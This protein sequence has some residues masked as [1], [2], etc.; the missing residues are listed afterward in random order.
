MNSFTKRSFEWVFY[1]TAALLFIGVLIRSVLIFSGSAYLPQ[2]L[3]L[4]SAWLVLAASETIISKRV[5]YYF[6]LYLVC[7]TTLVFVLINTPDF[8][9]FFAALLIIISMQV[10][11]RLNPK[12]GFAWMGLCALIMV[13]VMFRT[14]QSQAVALAL[15]YTGANIL[16]GSY[17][18]AARRSQEARLQN[19]SLAKQL[20]E[21]NNDLN[22]LSVQREEIAL[23]KE[24]SRLA[25][26]MHD[27]VTQTV[28][29]M[30]LAAQS[31]QLMLA[32]EPASVENQLKRI[33]NL[34]QRALS[35]MKLLVSELNLQR[36]TTG[37]L[38]ASLRHYVQVH[39]FPENFRVDIYTEGN[40]VLSSIEEEA[41][42]RIALEGLN[43]IMKHARTSE[44][45]IRLHLIEPFSLEI[46]DKGQGFEPDKSVRSGMG[47]KNMQE[48]A[49]E[50]GWTMTIFSSLGKGT[51]IRVEKSLS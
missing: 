39:S 45:T 34:S 17:T 38:A 36:V 50:I 43:N 3:G 37:G 15:I 49:K 12:A 18:L 14:Y 23:M 44:A 4:L 2:V 27:S 6:L 25:R 51:R 29:S 16:F 20:Q 30:S 21:A 35:E 13:L 31:A 11:I 9:D 26:D 33:G 28:F 40:D 46:E 41:L 7:Q 47:L 8:E 10:M 5:R 48:Q 22:A 32:R 42:F 24:R 19:E 1:L